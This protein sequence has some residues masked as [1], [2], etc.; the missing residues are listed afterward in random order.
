VRHQ[1]SLFALAVVARPVTNRELRGLAGL[2]IDATVRPGLEAKPAL[3]AVARRG[4]VNTFTLTPDGKDWCESAL[5]TGRPDGSR[6]PAGVLYAVLGRVG[7]YLDRDGVKFDEFFRPD[8]EDWI[9]AAYAELTTRRGPGAWVKLAKLRPWLEGV[10]RNVV[11]A[12]L[13]RMIEQPDVQLMASSI[14][15]RSPRPT[16]RPQWTSRVSRAIF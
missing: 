16:I 3:V 15:A 13:D 14:S 8:I 1:A 2:E 5:S 7:S 10:P 11:D 12:E 9:R 4:T 6:F